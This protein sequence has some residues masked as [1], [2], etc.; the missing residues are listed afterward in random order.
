MRLKPLRFTAKT[1]LLAAI[2]L[3]AASTWLALHQR[4]NRF[5]TMTLLLRSESPREELFEELADQLPDPT[6]FLER[7]RATGKVPHRRLV[8]AFLSRKAAENP[9]WFAGAGQLVLEG[10]VDADMSVR[11]LALAALQTRAD[12]RLFDCVRA[13]LTDLDP[14]V[15][16]LGL[17][18]LRRLDARR[19][20]PIT[21][22]LLDDPDPRIAAG[23]ETALMNWTG[24]DFG[25]RTYLAV[26]SKAGEPQL[27]P[28]RLDKIRRGIERRKEWWH[29]HAKEFPA[30]QVM[31]SQMEP[32]VLPG[33][34]VEDFILPDLEGRPVRLAEF[35]GKTVLLNFWATW[36]TACLAEIPDLVALQKKHDG[37]LV[38]LG[39]ALDGLPDEDGHQPGEE[40]EGR[41]HTGR[42]SRRAALDK[43]A[44]AVKA[45]GI[46]YPVSLDP[47]AAVGRR[48]NGGELPTTVI[49]D[50]QGRLRRRFIGERSLKVFEA[51]IAEAAKP[52]PKAAIH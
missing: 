43:V 39:V 17:N 32:G 30:T 42:P 14:L 38:I 20:V 22:E 6:E 19:A 2:L 21:M 28:A 29:L 8:A 35:R 9:A 44:R 4:I 52:L 3:V 7:C 15:R 36:C 37:Y 45:R 41:A 51:M 10:A 47:E 5:L 33:Q 12:P 50:A 16:E 49:I 18:C 24:Q 11:E 23:A 46:N 25:V 31:S 48:F 34:M 40:G 1:W 26:P 27:D 13:Q